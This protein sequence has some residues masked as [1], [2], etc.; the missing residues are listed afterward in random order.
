MNR[1]VFIIALI[2]LTGISSARYISISTSVSVEIIVRGDS[3]QVGVKLLNSG[4]EPAY[5]VRLSLLLP[6]GFSATELTPGKLDPDKPYMGNFTV[7]IDNKVLT[8]T[9]PIVIL[10]EYRDA[11]S[12]PF[13]SVTQNSLNVR[14]K[15]PPDVF[16]VLSRIKIGPEGS[17]VTTL[18]VRN[19]GDKRH[20]IRIRFFLPKELEM[21]SHLHELDIGARSQEELKYKISSFGALT[22]STYVAFASIE[23]DEDNLHYSSTASGTVEI[24]NEED[25]PPLDDTEEN[26]LEFLD[27]F[28]LML[29]LLMGSFLILLIVFAAVSIK[30]RMKN[31]DNSPRKKG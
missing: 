21:K 20:R 24:V 28:D 27:S 19:R 2:A 22:G 17:A 11:N 4:D 13:S 29:W 16:G 10:T 14:G 25:L 31:E 3:T 23:Y 6:E 12:Y 7:N 26:P 9:H 5:D 1:Q 18:K 15:T 30:N 8:G